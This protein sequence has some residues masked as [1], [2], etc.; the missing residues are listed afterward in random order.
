MIEFPTFYFGIANDT[1]SLHCNIQM[2]EESQEV[3]DDKKEDLESGEEEVDDESDDDSSKDDSLKQ[4]P[5]ELLD[6]IQ[7]LLAKIENVDES[8]LIQ[9][10]ENIAAKTSK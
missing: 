10:I 5:A 7:D 3:S 2:I 6:N 1:T 9:E 8:T 4:I